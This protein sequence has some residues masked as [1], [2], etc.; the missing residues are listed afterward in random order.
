MMPSY[1][2]ATTSQVAPFLY[3]GSL[4]YVDG[5]TTFAMKTDAKS[6]RRSPLL[7]AGQPNI[8]AI[9]RRWEGAFLLSLAAQRNSNAA[10]NLGNK[11]ASAMIRVVRSLCTHYSALFQSQLPHVLVSLI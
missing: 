3:E 9:A 6:D 1:A 10:L 7:W 11:S 5:N 8:L 2:Q 4:V